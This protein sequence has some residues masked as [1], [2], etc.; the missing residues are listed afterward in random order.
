MRREELQ[1]ERGDLREVRRLRE[2][3]LRERE[4]QHHRAHHD[5][6]DR[7]DGERR[8]HGRIGRPGHRR[9][10]Q[11]QADDVAAAGRD[12][13]VEAVAREVRAPDVEPSEARL[14]V[15]RAQDV[16]RRPRAERQVGGERQQG[17]QQGAPV[18]GR[19]V[20]EER[21]DRVE[22]L[23]ERV[24]EGGG[25]D[26]RSQY[27][28]SGQKSGIVSASFC[29]S[30]TRFETMITTASSG[31]S[32]QTERTTCGGT[33]TALPAS[34]STT[35]SSSLNWSLPSA[36][37]YISSAFLWRCPYEPLPPVCCG[38]RRQVKATLSA[39]SS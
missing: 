25:G 10:G 14:R 35:S 16:E 27:R 21:V 13:R 7:L 1:V 2:R 3:A 5:V 26:H 37:K 34:T 17:Q 31:S 24:A 8:G 23:A 33:S 19:Q 15:G 9:L 39:P 38:M 30:S 6:E 12:D 11:E 4:R 20:R 29:G 22:E 32:F 36:T 18:N 28:Y